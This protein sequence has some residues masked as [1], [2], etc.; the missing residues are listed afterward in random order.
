MLLITHGTQAV[1]D[2]YTHYDTGEKEDE[3]IF[4]LPAIP[5]LQSPSQR[6]THRAFGA[7][8]VVQAKPAGG[9]RQALQVDED[10]PKTS[11]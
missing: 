3:H 10:P 4:W 2:I 11:V 1:T 6:F 7:Q 5:V 9:D 8:L